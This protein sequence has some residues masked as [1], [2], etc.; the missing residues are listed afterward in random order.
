MAE[1]QKNGGTAA[2]I[3]AEHA[4]DSEYSKVRACSTDLMPSSCWAGSVTMKG[5]VTACWLDST[6]ISISV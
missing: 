5:A 1:V 6:S 3:D 4:F 2:L